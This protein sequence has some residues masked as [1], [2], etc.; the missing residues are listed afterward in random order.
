[1]KPGLFLLESKNNKRFLAVSQIILYFLMKV[2]AP[3]ASLVAQMVKNLPA[4]Q[5][6]QVQSL[7]QEDPWRKKWQPIPVFLPGEFHGQKR[8]AGCSPWITKNQT[9]LS[10]FHFTSHSQGLD[11]CL[12]ESP[13][14]NA[15]GSPRKDST[16][17]TQGHMRPTHTDVTTKPPHQIQRGPHSLSQNRLT[18]PRL[19]GTSLWLPDNDSLCSDLQI[20]SVCQELSEKPGWNNLETLSTILKK[21][22][23]SLMSNRLVC[24]HTHTYTHTHILLL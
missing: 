19:R 17:K 3:W 1:M 4:M 8:L 23:H 2:T 7:G 24:T 20:K 6:T 11:R 18:C 21:V 13:V 16:A 22:Y 15:A 12:P 9:W 14:K 5:E 10:D